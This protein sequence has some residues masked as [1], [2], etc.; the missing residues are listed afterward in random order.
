MR[1]VTLWFS[2]VLVVVVSPRAEVRAANVVVAAGQSVQKA[3]DDA[4]EGSEIT[5]PPGTFPESLTITKSLTLQGAGWEK[6][7]VGPD[8]VMPFT[9]KQKDEFFA[10]LEAA[11]DLQERAKIAVALATRQGSSTL[12]VKDAKRAVLR[13]ITF[14]GPSTAGPG[15]SIT[16]ESLVTFDKAAGSLVECAVVGPYM[17]GIA[18]GA[19][20]EVTIE[21]S[22]VAAVWGTGVAAASGTTLRMTD[23]DVRNCYHRCVTIATDEATIERCRISGS[24]WHGIRYDNCS[25]RILSNHIF[26]NARSGIYASGRT[27]AVVRGNVFWRNEM[28]AMSCWF[29]NADTVEGNTIVGNLREGIAVIGGARTNLVRNVFLDNPVGVACSKAAT[30][31]RRPEET[32]SGDPTVAVNVFFKNPK[33]WQDGLVLKPLPAGNLSVDPRVGDA[34]SDFRMAPDS[35]A[36]QANAGALNPIAFAS[37]FAIQPGE[38]A[39]IPDSETRASSKWKKVASSR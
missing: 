38:A 17:N 9:Q 23:S 10:A 4:P 35:P 20:S 37:P 36:R 3:I 33:A 26:A 32:P 24:A 11:G 29:D 12:I 30:G 8:R 14:R 6:T 21:R 16:T 13:G 1:W 19:G 5:L 28:D 2:A 15:D 31:G 39:M 18:I 27:S 22:L 25:P 7:T 34:A